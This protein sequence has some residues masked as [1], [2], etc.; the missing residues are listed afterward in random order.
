MNWRRRGFQRQ[1]IDLSRDE[2]QVTLS[3]SIF[4]I[5][6][7]GVLL[8]GF[9]QMEMI[10][11]SSRYLEDALAA[12]G[13]ASALIDVREYGRTHAVRIAD[14]EEAYER[15]REALKAN[16]GLNEAWEC[17]NQRLISGTVTVEN[18]T[19]YNVTGEAVVSCRLDGGR[20]ET[21]TGR[22][23][24]VLAPNGIPVE[25]TGVYGEVSYVLRGLFGMEIPA[26]KG[27]LI[28][29]AGEE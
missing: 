28:D 20:A 10:R 17:D 8:F 9:L 29:V 26:R 3:A 14:G 13:L 4:F 27:K 19:I 21:V 1:S 2:G 7:L 11:S 5:L 25:K 15:Y 23:G 16:L 22:K 6:F 18:Y 12:S 24:E